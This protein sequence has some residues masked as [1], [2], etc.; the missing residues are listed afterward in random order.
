MS[1][2]KYDVEA[3]S[4]GLLD[5][6]GLPKLQ[7]EY[8]SAPLRGRQELEEESLKA[9]HER[10]TH[11][12]SQGDWDRCIALHGKEL[13]AIRARFEP[14]FSN[15]AGQEEYRFNRS[16]VHRTVRHVEGQRGESASSADGSILI[17]ALE[18]P[19][20]VLPVIDEIN[21]R[22]IEHL[23]RFPSEL[24]NLKSHMFE[25]L[26]AEILGGRGWSVELTSRSRDNGI[27]IIACRDLADAP[28][29]LLVQCK[30][31]AP[32]R[33]VGISV[34][35]ELYATKLDLGASLAMVATTSSFTKP[36]LRFEER[37]RF[38]LSL[39]DFDD[40]VA[41]LVCHTLPMRDE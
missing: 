34:V 5:E 41:W 13:E 40:I 38:E 14:V 8:V 28:T 21:Q 20:I 27:D 25:E 11:C 12:E 16:R 4:F 1:Y 7:E 24:R 37:H 22:A 10:L 36:A 23:A 29:Q 17:C 35:K 33:R 9:Y 2:H 3:N 19:T 30:R 39:H 26:I 18:A 31:Y 15:G 6:D 32:H